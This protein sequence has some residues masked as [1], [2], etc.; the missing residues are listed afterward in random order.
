MF[1]GCSGFTSLDLSNFNTENVTNM[2]SMFRGCSSLTSLNV[3]SFNTDNV[4]DMSRMF[5]YCS[6]LS[7]IDVSK[8]NTAEVSYMYFM[9]EGCSG[10]TS[11][12]VS[13]FNTENVT[14]MNGMFNGCSELTTLDISNFNT[15]NVIYMNGMFMYCNSLKNIYVG[16]KWNT[17]SVTSS[18]SMF[19]D[20]TKL[21]GGKGT[22]YNSDFTDI[23]YA[24]IDDSENGNPGYFT[25]VGEPAFVPAEPYVVFSDGT[26]TFYYDKNKP[27]GA[28]GIRT[29]WYSE[30]SDIADKITKV[31]FDKS[32]ADYRPTNCAYWF[33]GCENLTVTEGM[34]EYLNTENVTSMDYMFYNCSSLT[35]LDISNFNTE[36]V[37]NM[38]W[39]FY[40]CSN[41]QT[42]YVG[43]NWNT[44]NLVYSWGM[45]DGCEKLVGGKGT[46]YQS[47]YTNASYA[48]IDGGEAAPG[49]LSRREPY[50]VFDEKESTLTLYYDGNKPDGAYE[51]R[52]S[53]D[54]AW[55]KI[56]GQ[57]TKVVFDKSFA[58][59][60]PTS[61]AY[62]FYGCYNLTEIIGM[63]EYLNTENVTSMSSMFS[64]CWSLTSLDL[65]SF[66]TENV[67][68]MS[69]MFG[70]CRSLTSLN[71]NSFNTE[72]VTN[73][74]GMFNACNRLP[75]LDLSNFNTENVSDMQYMF[76][77]CFKLKTI[78]AGDGWT[79]QNVRYSYFGMFSDCNKLYGQ[80]GSSFKDYGSDIAYAHIDGG[81]NNP[82]FLTRVGDTPWAAT[83]AYAI[84]DDEG[85]LT[86][87]FDKNMP[88]TGAFD[89]ETGDLDYL[90]KWKSNVKTAV[91]DKSFADYKP[92]TCSGWFAYC[93]NMTSIVGMAE[94][95]NTE[96]VT[97]MDGMFNNCCSL[98]D[99]DLRGFN[100]ENV[101]YMSAMFCCCSNLAS[102][103]LSGFNTQNVIN[104]KYMFSDCNK[105]K[106]IYVGDGWTTQSVGNYD[107]MFFYCNKLYGSQGSSFADYG[108]D[109][110]YARIDGG[111]DNPGFLTRVGDKPWVVPDAY[112]LLDDDGTLTFYYGYNM[113][114]T[115]AYDVAGGD[116]HNLEAWKS[117]VKTAVF[118]KSFA[119][120]KPA[121]C[122][123]WFANCNNMTA[124]VGM[125]EYLNTE[126]VTDM[127]DMFR[128]CSSLTDIDLS[129]FNTSNV[130]SM[131]GMF[132]S[133]S[134]LA[135]LDL[136]NFNTHN[137]YDM[138]SM[139][140]SCSMLQTIYVGD[141]WTTQNVDNYDDMFFGCNKLY[142]S[143]GSS[144]IDYGNDIV[145][146]RIDGGPDAPGYFTKADATQK[147]GAITITT[148][149]NSITASIDGNY[150]GTDA[151]SITKDIDVTSVT[152]VRDFTENKYSSVVLPFDAKPNASD[153]TFY[154]FNGVSYDE[155]KD[156][157][158]ASISSVTSLKAH[159]PY[160][161]EPNGNLTSLTWNAATTIET[162]P[163][164]VSTE[165]T[166]ETYGKWIF[167]AVYETVS[168]TDRQTKIYGFAGI[169]KENRDKQQVH[170]GDFVRAGYNSSI[171]PF[172]CYL[173]Y[174]GGG[175]IDLS[176]LSKSSLALPDRIEVRV[177][178]GV[179]DPDAPQNN[180]SSNIETPTSEIAPA[181][182]VN[183]WSYDKAIYI[184]TMPNTPYTI[185]DVNGR[186]LQTG[187]TATDRDEIHLP[188]KA[189][190]IVI[191]IVGDKSFKIRY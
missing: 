6:E 63:K 79:T 35:T 99:I 57:T 139:F 32:V 125:A 10:L 187:I 126:K 171:K 124:I 119:D 186:P 44:P 184:A 62:W 97:N 34:K 74:S 56:A 28:Y 65:R 110:A 58:D 162:P 153:G 19:Y 30:W 94:Y 43:D 33:R 17:E 111:F 108:N 80:Q 122:Y 38:G 42:I 40:N 160:I 20:C 152:L 82:G 13:N 64:D 60:R 100:T 103:D 101:I 26:L 154:T 145:Y 4:T 156:V 191:V 1:S 76:N 11:I 146:A 127:D 137:V 89:V 41:L 185:V 29:G 163:A 157:W 54:N 183:V 7:S 128:N 150:T 121:T 87:Y 9:F 155:D 181:A 15:E 71:L 151:L 178:S 70:S 140:N 114:A 14:Y 37:T 149:G 180:S 172:R 134:N 168:W 98:T 68:D 167:K 75:N 91:F 131:E 81:S 169:D 130:I 25:R 143:Q 142:G 61:C 73:M 164:S 92:V 5:L 39:M 69:G 77:D 86:F 177:V 136:S 55:Y 95:L 23:T 135:S 123:T 133:C 18:E 175:E 117:N 21:Y 84:L 46:T 93:D 106:T 53:Y 188:S 52:T 36:N 2:G 159:T 88:V 115:G 85:T 170:I 158:I 112:A 179:L 24:R 118:D 107:D 72:N 16:D 189:D 47:S 67:T 147:L 120:Y 104:M 66:N 3:N 174:I 166:D 78:Y 161:F 96:N 148:D 132:H 173:E 182:N 144:F 190:G 176:T 27:D 50:A 8:F 31:V 116:L 45:F 102:L 165:V 48:R 12:D 49:Y 22:A 59:Y 129:G 83:D 105:L 138:E 51:M 90:A 109:I 113:P 141:G